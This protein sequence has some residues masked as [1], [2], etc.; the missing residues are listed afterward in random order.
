MGC[1]AERYMSLEAI[2]AFS[3]DPSSSCQPLRQLAQSGP[4][5]DHDDV[6]VTPLRDTSCATPPSDRETAS[7]PFVIIDTG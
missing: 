2:A 4:A 3:D 1:A 5:D 7:E 6:A